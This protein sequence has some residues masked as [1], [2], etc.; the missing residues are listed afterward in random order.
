MAK[1]NP[2]RFYNWKKAVWLLSQGP[3][4]LLFLPWGV[5]RR[6]EKKREHSP[7]GWVLAQLPRVDM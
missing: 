4:M 2:C 1:Q 7:G 6:A 5:G 3:E